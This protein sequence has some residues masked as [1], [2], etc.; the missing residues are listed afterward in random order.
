MLPVGFHHPYV[1]AL[2][3]AV[4]SLLRVNSPEQEEAASGTAEGAELTPQGLEPEGGQ[5]EAV[6]SRAV[7]GGQAE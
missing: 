2:S 6:K 3:Q 7:P 4:I 5:A 1:G